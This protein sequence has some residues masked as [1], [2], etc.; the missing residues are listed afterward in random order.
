[1]PRAIRFTITVITTITI[2]MIMTASI[3]SSIPPISRAS[4]RALIVVSSDMI[5][6]AQQAKLPIINNW[7]CFRAFDLLLFQITKDGSV[8]ARII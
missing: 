7:G 6:H 8:I 4:N 2:D 5:P 1:M 3:V